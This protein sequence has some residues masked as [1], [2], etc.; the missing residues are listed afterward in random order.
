VLEE[1]EGLCMDYRLRLSTSI[2]NSACRGNTTIQVQYPNKIT[3]NSNYYKRYH[4][5]HM[6]FY[7][8]C[9][10]D[11]VG[12]YPPHAVTEEVTISYT[13][14]SHSTIEPKSNSNHVL[15]NI[16]YIYNTIV[17]KT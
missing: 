12:G 5:K 16:V 17:A 7:S 10:K 8:K 3:H 2:N 11:K 6:S 1:E 13:Y 9:G 4:A 15:P 14:T